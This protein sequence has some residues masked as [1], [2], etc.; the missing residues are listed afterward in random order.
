MYIGIDGNE[1]NTQNRVGSNVY[2]HQLL[3]GIHRLDPQTQYKIYL[4]HPPL[5][6]L[7]KPTSHWHYHSFGP[8]KL[9]TQW[10][11][12][13]ELY[14]EKTKPSIFFTPGHYA[15]RFSPVPTVISIM[16][17]A[18]LF[19]PQT[20]KPSV[21]NQ[22]KSWTKYSVT[23]AKHIFAISQNTKN[24]LVKTYHLDP[25][26]I[27]VTYLGS[28]L[29]LDPGPVKVDQTLQK[30]NLPPKYLL[31]IGTRQPRKNL[32]RLI[33][34][35]QILQTSHKDL[36]LV[37]VGKTWDQFATT[38]LKSHPHLHTTGYLPEEQ[39][40]CVLKGAQAFVF[41]SLYEGFGLPLVEALRLGVPVA[42]SA[43]SSIPEITG[44]SPFLFDPK[45]VDEIVQKTHDLLNLSQSMR[46]KLIQE[47][48]I[49]AKQF[50]WEKTTIKTLE[51]IHE[52][53]LS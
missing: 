40:A 47:G 24:D 14:L 7:P 20:F 19:F 38:K 12:P 31:F 5:K 32:D 52:L 10:R 36:H 4:K 44:P 37:I 25:D 41:P 39:L 50:T 29:S 42:A 9:W 11:L 6:D 8:T 43:V 1:A 28:N 33:E 45:N 15:P 23:N 30:L 46:Q 3:R 2:A 26:K 22:L 27:T 48:K 21:L 53:A 16:D 49:R 35:F 17:L 13:L 18:F 34:A 51:V